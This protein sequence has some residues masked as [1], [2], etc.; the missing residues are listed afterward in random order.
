FHL[1]ISIG[2]VF[3]I[4]STVSVT[5]QKWVTVSSL[6]Q[7]EQPYFLYAWS[8]L[9][10]LGALVSYPLFFESHFDL[11]QQIRIWRWGYFIL[12]AGAAAL[13]AFLRLMPEQK[14]SA[15]RSRP[16][17]ARSVVFRWLLLSAAGVVMFLGVTNVITNEIAPVPLLWVVPLAIYL[18]AFILTFREPSLCPAWIKNQIWLWVGLGVVLHL[19][20]EAG[21]ITSLSVWGLLLYCGLL[22]VVCMYCQHELYQSRP[23]DSRGLTYFYAIISLGS[24]LG[25]IAVSWVVPLLSS[26]LIELLLAFCILSLALTADPRLAGDRDFYLRLLA[27]MWVFMVQNCPRVAGALLTAVILYAV[28]RQLKE[29]PRVVYCVLLAALY[30]VPLFRVDL[31]QSNVIYRHR[32][33]YGIMKI[34]EDR[35]ARYFVHGQTVHGAQFLDPARQQEPLAYF[36][37][38]TPIGQVMQSGRFQFHNVGIIGLGAGALAAYAKEG[39]AFDFLELDPDVYAT[40]Q[41]YFTYLKNSRGKIAYYWGDARLSLDQ[42]PSG[43]YDLFIVDAFGGDAVPIHLLTTEAIAKYRQ[44]LKEDGLLLFHFTNRYLRLDPVLG[45]NALELKAFVAYQENPPDDANLVMESSWFAMTWDA[46][47]HHIL[48]NDLGWQD[49]DTGRVKNVRPWMDGYSNIVPYIKF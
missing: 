5:L 34:V 23:R 11:T 7:R 17:I 6:P 39:M 49:V 22:F 46:Q 1:L 29:K 4:L 35:R 31:M 20:T 32:N 48:V 21:A 12:I 9:G 24:F 25:G 3:F 40:A 41:K 37:Y 10:S 13:A 42:I 15:D 38:S 45:R 16:A 27:V 26:G 2:P 43:K 8:N 33:Y 14:Q 36:H 19:L 18:A 28:W 47:K 30:L 44:C